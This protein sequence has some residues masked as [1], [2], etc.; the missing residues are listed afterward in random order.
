MPLG[1]ALLPQRFAQGKCTFFL[2]R[3]EVFVASPM[4]PADLERP[5]HGSGWQP[6][7][8]EA[9]PGEGIANLLPSTLHT[10]VPLFFCLVTVFSM[11]VGK[12]VCDGSLCRFDASSGEQIA[13]LLPQRREC[14][15]LS[16]YS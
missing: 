13:D 10:V 1:S 2:K 11:K 7:L 16:T 9:P 12:D 6:G 4:I 8:S 5:F 15:I 14:M 3:E